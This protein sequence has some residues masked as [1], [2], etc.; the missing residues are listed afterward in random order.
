MIKPQRLPVVL[1]I[2][3]AYLLQEGAISTLPFQVIHLL[4]GHGA[5]VGDIQS[6]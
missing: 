5:F 4:S 3:L 1:Q 2:E 6:H